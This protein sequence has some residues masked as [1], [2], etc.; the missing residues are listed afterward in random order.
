M[1]EFISDGPF[2]GIDALLDASDRAIRASVEILKRSATTSE[3]ARRVRATAE[4]LCA[5]ASMLR[6]LPSLPAKD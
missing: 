6:K 3:N 4:R 1:K 2:P 5:E